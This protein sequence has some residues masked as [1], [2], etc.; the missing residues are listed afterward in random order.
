M[1]PAWA[2]FLT[3]KDWGA[4]PRPFTSLHRHRLLTDGACRGSISGAAYARGER[5][6]SCLY[7]VS[8]DPAGNE[9]VEGSSLKAHIS[10]G[11]V[12][13]FV[14]NLDSKVLC[15]RPRRSCPVIFGRISWLI[16]T[17]NDND[18]RVF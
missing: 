10:S 5:R 6:G 1:P 17:N 13:A 15:C 7:G 3:A 4:W 2:H 12:D 18:N 8:G 9:S 11:D 16:C 14:F